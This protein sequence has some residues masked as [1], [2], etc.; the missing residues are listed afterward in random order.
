MDQNLIL[1]RDIAKEIL[2]IE[3]VTN[4]KISEY[5]EEFYDIMRRYGIKQGSKDPEEAGTIGDNF[6]WTMSR[7]LFLEHMHMEILT[8][9]LIHP[10][11]EDLEYY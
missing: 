9:M 1:M 11:P 5:V 8:Y 10:V 6:E 4:K 3:I 2:N 7:T